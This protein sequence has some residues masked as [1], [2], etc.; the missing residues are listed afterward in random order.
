VN[1]KPP[2]ALL[3][4]CLLLSACASV[5]GGAHTGEVIIGNVPFYP[6]EDHQCGPASLAG[7]L[8]FRGMQITPEEIAGAIF[9]KTA[10]G[11]LTLDMALYAQKKGLFSLEYSGSMSDLREKIDAGNPL[12]VM[13]DNG[14]SIWQVNHF[15]VVLGYNDDGVIVNSGKKEHEFIDNDKFM[16]GWT[17][18]GFWSLLITN[19]N[20]KV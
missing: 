10:R 12:I 20:E 8:Q 11:T 7:V 2:A 18:T 17:R 1:L 4:V 19:K 6:Q 5:P 16:K 3:F 15:M 13:V 14:I 9:S